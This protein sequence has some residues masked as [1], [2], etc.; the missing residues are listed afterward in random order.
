MLANR[1]QIGDRPFFMET[2]MIDGI[3]ID[4]LEEFEL[5]QLLYAKRFSHAIG[6]SS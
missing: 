6:A 1:F 3:D 4:T 5:A 2:S